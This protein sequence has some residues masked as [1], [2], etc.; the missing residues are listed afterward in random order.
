VDE[1]WMAHVGP[2]SGPEGDMLEFAGDRRQQNSRLSCQITVSEALD[3][4]TVYVPEA[5]Y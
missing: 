5:Q 3:G 1:A 4:L 2:A